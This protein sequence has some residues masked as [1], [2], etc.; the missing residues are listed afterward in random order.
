MPLNAAAGKKFT[1]SLLPSAVC[2]PP[3]TLYALVACWAV[4]AVRFVLI[5]IQF[6]EVDGKYNYEKDQR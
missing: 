3:H 2:G 6:N 1:H 5:E 4:E